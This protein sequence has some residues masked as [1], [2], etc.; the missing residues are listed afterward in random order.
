LDDGVCGELLNKTALLV[1]VEI[2]VEGVDGG[3]EGE[4]QRE[5]EAHFG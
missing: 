3:E 4:E 5:D 2:K 1:G